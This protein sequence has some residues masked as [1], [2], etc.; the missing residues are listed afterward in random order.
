[1]HGVSVPNA[2]VFQGSTILTFGKRDPA[3]II[4]V[5]KL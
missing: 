3:N 1:M 4:K 2:S 5:L